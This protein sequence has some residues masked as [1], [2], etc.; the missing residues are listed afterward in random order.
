LAKY[1]HDIHQNIE[2]SS[3]FTRENGDRIKIDNLLYHLYEMSL[4]LE[5]RIGDSQSGYPTLIIIQDDS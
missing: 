3:I 2:S 5:V 4:A 1:I